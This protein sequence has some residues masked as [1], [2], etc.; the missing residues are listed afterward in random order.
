M[1][2]VLFYHSLVSD[3]NHGNP[4]PPWHSPRADRA[5]VRGR[6]VQA[7]GRLESDASP[8][9]SRQASPRRVPGSVCRAARDHLRSSGLDLDRAARGRRRG[10][11]AEWNAPELVARIRPTSRRRRRL[12]RLLFHGGAPPPRDGAGPHAGIQARYV[13]QHLA[14][15]EVV[16]ELYLERGWSAAPGPG[17]RP[18]ICDCAGQLKV[19][20]VRATSSGSTTGATVSVQ[21]SSTAFSSSRCAVTGLQPG[22]TA[23]VIPSRLCALRGR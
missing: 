16:R 12:P 8:G 3:W 9:G 13:R 11:R 4:F 22:S 6:A 17:V 23:S 21:L 10:H 7:G 5:W 15:G 19:S 14:F 1:K 2:V 18:P 20:G